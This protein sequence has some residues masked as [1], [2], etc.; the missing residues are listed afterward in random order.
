MS[1]YLNSLLLRVRALGDKSALFLMLPSLLVAFLVDA[2][3]AETITEW[4]VMVPFMAGLTVLLSR[5]MFPYIDFPRLL[6]EV[7]LE[8]R[9]AAVVVAGLMTFCGLLMLAL[10]LWARA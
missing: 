1:R 10:I 6:D 7:M 3:M 4:L 9:G 8:N 2:P 5:V